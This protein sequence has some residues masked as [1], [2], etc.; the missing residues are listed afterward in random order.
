VAET[1]TPVVVVLVG[2]IVF[3]VFFHFTSTI[4]ESLLLFLSCGVAKKQDTTTPTTPVQSVSSFQ[5]WLLLSVCVPLNHALV[6]CHALFQCQPV[7]C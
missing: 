6:E 4:V 5:Q 2:N 7:C 1:S 3:F